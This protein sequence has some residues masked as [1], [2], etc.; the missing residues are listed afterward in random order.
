MCY[1]STYRKWYGTDD[2]ASN[3]P[4]CDI[5]CEP[6]FAYGSTKVASKIE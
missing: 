4:Q 3:Y 1:T 6:R 5:I 2:N